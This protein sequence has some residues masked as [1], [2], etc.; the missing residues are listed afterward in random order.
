MKMTI[1]RYLDNKT[2]DKKNPTDKRV[3][4]LKRMLVGRNILEEV[5]LSLL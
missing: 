1:K 4:G 3:V 2:E 5:A